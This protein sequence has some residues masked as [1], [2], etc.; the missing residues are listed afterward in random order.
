M[1]TVVR[2]TLTLVIVLT[3]GVASVESAPERPAQRSS[4]LDRAQAA[5]EAGHSVEALS[6]VRR[7]AD[8]APTG[9]PD[10]KTSAPRR[11]RP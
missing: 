3:L 5:F 8:T 10:R 7:A 1:T 11:I 2:K 6:L 4:D 9:W